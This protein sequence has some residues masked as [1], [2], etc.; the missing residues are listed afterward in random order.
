M[1]NKNNLN[2]GQHREDPRQECLQQVLSDVQGSQ[3]GGGFEGGGRLLER[4]AV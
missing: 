1:I 3:G 2:K 4:K